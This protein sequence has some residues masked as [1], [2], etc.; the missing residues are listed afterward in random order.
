MA[1][2]TT[3][4]AHVLDLLAPL[5]PVTA[6]AMFGGH[7]LYLD[8]V[9]F[10]LL[11]DEE[12]YL[13]TDAQTVERF[14]GAGCKPWVYPGPRG[15]MVTQNYRP[16]DEAFEDAEAMLPWA[17]LA[18]GSAR[19]RAAAKKTKR[20]KSPRAKKAVSARAAPSPRKRR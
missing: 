1:V 9:M 8:G 10:G 13:R 4:V 14:K 15:P 17:T 12:L 6:R 3:F 11:D 5:G 16:P 18:L 7:G 19:A 20:A 2:S